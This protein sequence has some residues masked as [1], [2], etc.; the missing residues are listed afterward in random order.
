ME[1]GNTSRER[2][3]KSVLRE[4]ITY[5]V[6]L[7]VL[8]VC[9]Y[10]SAPL[11]PFLYCLLAVIPEGRLFD[12]GEELMGRCLG[13]YLESDISL[14]SAHGLLLETENT[15]TFCTLISLEPLSRIIIHLSF[16]F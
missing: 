11:H 3:L 2:Y 13:K 5:M 16:F 8:C 9:E 15:T 6:F 12:V 14:F 4:L 1:E 7:V 10:C